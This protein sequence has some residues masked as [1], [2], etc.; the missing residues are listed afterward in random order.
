MQGSGR[1]KDG[2]IKSGKRF[3]VISFRKD[4]VPDSDFGMS[5]LMERID[6]ALEHG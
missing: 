5:I 3:P 1:V 6:C 2:G 4:G